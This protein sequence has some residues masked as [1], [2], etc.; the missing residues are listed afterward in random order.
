MNMTSIKIDEPQQ[1]GKNLEE[2][3]RHEETTER[4]LP[5][6]QYTDWLQWFHKTMQP[7]NY[8][9]I[10]VNTGKSLQYVSKDTLTVGVDPEPLIDVKLTSN[11]TVYS[12]TSDNFF[13]KLEVKALLNG[14]IQLAFVDGLH[15]YD[16]VLRDFI[17]IEK[18]STKDTVVLFHD[19]FPVVPETATRDWNTFYWA[20]DTWKFMHIINKYRTD[21]VART[22]P[23]FPTGLGFVTNLDNLS[24]VLEDNFDL[25]VKEYSAL[26]YDLYNSVNKINNDF[27]EIETLLKGK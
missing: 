11:T 4:L 15:H 24:T 20:G 2:K 21:L 6:V 17:N 5:G 19:V 8:L 9:E 23:T 3:A 1:A 13:N 27:N 25:I 12:E 16:Q 22:I 26:S 7:S 18:H 14:P 10:G